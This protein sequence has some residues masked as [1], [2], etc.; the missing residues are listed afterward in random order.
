MSKRNA[1]KQ[2][3]LGTKLRQMIGPLVGQL[4]TILAT[5]RAT[6]NVPDGWGMVNDQNG[7]PAAFVPPEKPEG[8][9][10]V[11]KK[12]AKKKE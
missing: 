4:N 11:V 10:A 7:I 8:P 6:L 5:A 12:K 2:I 3:A 9:K 1:K